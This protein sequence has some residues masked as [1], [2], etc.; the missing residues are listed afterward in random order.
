MTSYDLSASHTAHALS[1]HAHVP[2]LVA[3]DPVPDPAH[4][5][6]LVG[7]RADGLFLTIHPGTRGATAL[8]AIIRRMQDRWPLQL[9]SWFVVWG[10]GHLPFA[11]FIDRYEE[12]CAHQLHIAATPGSIPQHMRVR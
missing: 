1:R 7:E 3:V 12:H 10:Y 8:P 6:I 2:L 5:P 11:E 4:C 9:A